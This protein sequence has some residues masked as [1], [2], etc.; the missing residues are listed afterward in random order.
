MDNNLITTQLQI[1][2]YAD[3]QT[4]F[5]KDLSKWK[6]EM[7]TLDKAATK[8]D[9]T[10]TELSQKNCQRTENPSLS[11]KRSVAKAPSPVIY[12]SNQHKSSTG[13]DSTRTTN[14]SENERLRGNTFYSTG[15]YEEA[16]QAYT[17][18]L[19]IDPRSST[20]YSN[21]GKLPLESKNHVQSFLKSRLSTRYIFV[22]LL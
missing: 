9:A 17:K 15:R 11:I 1:R 12:R 5:L 19:Q 6:N 7:T 3:E 18:S 10:S 21:R 14:S 22:W 13:D 16:I 8:T 4:E 2:K 20:A